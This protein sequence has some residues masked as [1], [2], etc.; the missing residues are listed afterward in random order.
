[1][2]AFADL[3]ELTTL[4]VWNGVSGRVLGG[5]RV[6][7]AV[8]ELEPSAVVP[9]HNHEHEQIG[10]CV[11]G[12]VTYR[13]GDEERVLSPG[14]TWLIPGGVPHEVHT[15]PEGAVV[16]ETWAPRRE[17]WAALERLEGKPPRWPR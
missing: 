13:V 14:N 11:S 3:A 8:V 10:V 1:M 17:D 16:V 4:R 5:E 12:S 2:S 7:M 15:G 9:E 6:T